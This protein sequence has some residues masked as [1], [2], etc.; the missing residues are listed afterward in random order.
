MGA[1]AERHA[2]GVGAV[3]GSASVGLANCATPGRVVADVGVP[4]TL[5]IPAEAGIRVP[6][7]ARP[8][9]RRVLANAGVSPASGPPRPATQPAVSDPARS[10]AM[11]LRSLSFVPCTRGAVCSRDSMNFPV[12][13]RQRSRQPHMAPKPRTLHRGSLTELR[14]SA[15]ALLA[16]RRHPQDHGVE[17]TNGPVIEART[18]VLMSASILN[19][20]CT[21]GRP[22]GAASQTH[23][24]RGP[25]DPS[26]ERRY[27]ARTARPA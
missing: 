3:G 7:T 10:R 16:P 23:R 8:G 26:P 6:G 19:P 24:H 20:Q 25:P 22:T 2:C 4:P 15:Q 21:V 17:S 27:S 11:R 18:G 12:R 9:G 13:P 14:A 5:V 1:T